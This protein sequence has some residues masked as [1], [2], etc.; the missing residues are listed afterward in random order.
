[1]G[2]NPQAL[3]GGEARWPLRHHREAVRRRLNGTGP[4]RTLPPPPAAVFPSFSQLQA[5]HE[6]VAAGSHAGSEAL[7]VGLGCRQEYMR[8]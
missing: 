7:Q 3:V 5:G 4:S 1:M 6:A 8:F 2:S